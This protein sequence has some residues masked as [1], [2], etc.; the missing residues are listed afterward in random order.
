MHIFTPTNTHIGRKNENAE[1]KNK[2]TSNAKKNRWRQNGIKTTTH[3]SAFGRAKCLRVTQKI[4]TNAQKKT[5]P[6]K[7]RTKSLIC[8][9]QKQKDIH[10]FRRMKTWRVLYACYN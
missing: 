5:K 2:N 3:A 7:R 4:H 10:S 9:N 1:D 6:P 8:K